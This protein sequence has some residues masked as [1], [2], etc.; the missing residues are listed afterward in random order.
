MIEPSSKPVSHEPVI[1]EPV[2]LRMLCDARPGRLT[3]IVVIAGILGLRKDECLCLTRSD[4]NLERMISHVRHSVRDERDTYGHRVAALGETKTRSS[5]RDIRIPESLREELESALER[6]QRGADGLLF[7]AKDD[8][9]MATQILRNAFM[10]TRAGVPGLECIW[11]HDLRKAA[12]TGFAA[13]GA[14]NDEVTR[15]TGQ[16]LLD[17]ASICQHTFDSQLDGVYRRLDEAAGTGKST[18]DGCKA[19]TSSL[20]VLPSTFRMAA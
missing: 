17:V 7:P 2:Q 6:A 18:P 12:L 15:I 9:P 20:A 5:I 8:G 4:V 14:T 3:P 19:M 11:F 16:T 10:K 13:A 1:A